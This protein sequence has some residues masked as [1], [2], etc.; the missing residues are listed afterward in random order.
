MSEAAAHRQRYCN[1]LYRQYIVQT[2]ISTHLMRM[3]HVIWKSEGIGRSLIGYIRPQLY[4]PNGI[5]SHAKE[6]SEPV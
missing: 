1:I 4:K 6:K 5:D 3:R 2:S